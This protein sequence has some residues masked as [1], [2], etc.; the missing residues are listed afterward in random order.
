MSYLFLAV[1]GGLITELTHRV[2]AR[3]K[4]PQQLCERCQWIESL[5]ESDWLGGTD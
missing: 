3:R 4:Q 1:L 5:D 2:V